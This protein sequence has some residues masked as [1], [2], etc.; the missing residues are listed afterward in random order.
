MVNV[1]NSML[2]I[3]GKLEYLIINQ[4]SVN[5]FLYILQLHAVFLKIQCNYV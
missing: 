1:T 2:K 5:I 4:L 3:C